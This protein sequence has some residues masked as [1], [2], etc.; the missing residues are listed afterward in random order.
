MCNTSSPTT[1]LAG[2]SAPLQFAV[3]DEIEIRVRVLRI[4]ANDPDLP[5]RVCIVAGASV[6]FWLATAALV[7][8]RLVATRPLAVGDSVNQGKTRSPWP[9]VIRAIHGTKA[10]I[11]YDD[12]SGGQYELSDLTRWRA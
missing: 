7:A 8:G 11:Q 10:W 2:A 5:Y 9:A 1:K 12:A 3:G 6:P 4:D